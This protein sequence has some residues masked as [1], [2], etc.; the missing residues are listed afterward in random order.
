[1]IEMYISLMRL[2]NIFGAANPDIHK[3]I[4][5]YGDAHKVCEVIENGK[6]EYPD[7]SITEK[8]KYATVDKMQKI[9]EQCEKRDVHLVC[10]YE[11]SYP[12]ML[13][14]IYNPPVLLFYRGSLDC[15]K[16]K[17]LSAVGSREITAYIS[18]LTYKIATDLSKN[19]ITL[20]S[21]M[22]HGV[23]S[24]VHSACVNLGNPTVG[25]LGCGV[26]YDYPRGSSV[27]R[28]DII[29]NGGLY[30]SELFPSVS[31]SPE[32]FVARNRIIA[33]LSG[34]TIVFQAGVKSGSLI[35][36]DYAVQEGRDVFCVPP[37]DIMDEHYFGVIDFLR[38]GAIPVFNHDDILKFYESNF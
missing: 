16:N 18:K 24:T 9:I 23:D 1:M 5:Y 21:G 30:L 4:E 34:G 17:C 36:A 14:E 10:L 31:P 35:T 12:K 8:S 6:C 22:A 11:K 38:D 15:L 3:L 26:F 25:V 33:G 7:K 2:V 28:S 32:Y 19:G 13:K 29:R 27:L 20:I 37:P